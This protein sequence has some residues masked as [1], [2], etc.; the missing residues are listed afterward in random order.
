MVSGVQQP[1]LSDHEVLHFRSGSLYRYD[2]RAE[3]DTLLPKLTHQVK[4][5]QCY[6]Y[7]LTVSPNG[8]QVLWGV[9]ANNPLFVATVD[10][11][12]RAQWDGDGGMTDG[13]WCVD[14]TKWLQFHFG[15]TPTSIHWTNIEQHSLDA[16]HSTETFSSPPGL[17]GLDILAAPSLENIIARTPDPV[18]FQMPKPSAGVK[19]ADGSMAFT[20]QD[21][22]TLRS[23]QTISVWSLRQAEP[24][25]KWIITLPGKVQEVAVS[26]DGQRATWLLQDNGGKKFR[27]SLWVSKTDG[28]GLHKIGSFAAGS[29]SAQKLGN[30]FPFS[31][32]WVPGNTQISFQY[33]NA[34]WAVAAD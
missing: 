15:G 11:A 19:Q 3:T 32:V 2:A 22:P 17:N 21:K 34:L 16:P 7:F 5:S 18:K 30:A 33:G 13:Y 4:S 14:G 8:Q 24:I 23:V 26:P 1:W 10:G 29:A 28:S 9:S 27:T 12:Q 20:F 6:L 25:H 31:L